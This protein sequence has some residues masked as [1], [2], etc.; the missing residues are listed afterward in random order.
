LKKRK[1]KLSWTLLLHYLLPQKDGPL[2]V[3]PAD[4]SGRQTT[5]TITDN[6]KK[7]HQMVLDDHRD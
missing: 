2:V 4:H 6:I 7:V 1:L 5:A 3:E